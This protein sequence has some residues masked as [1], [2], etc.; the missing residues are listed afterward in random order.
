MTSV[1]QEIANRAR[2]ILLILSPPSSIP[3]PCPQP[4]VS[5]HVPRGVERSDHDGRAPQQIC[6][7]PES[8]KETGQPSLSAALN[9]N[10]TVLGR[11]SGLGNG[12]GAARQR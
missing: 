7:P 3:V 10:R 6:A 4:W 2:K 11:F 9:S 8:R 1:H 12:D 5:G